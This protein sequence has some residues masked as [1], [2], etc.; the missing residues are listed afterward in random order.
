MIKLRWIVRLK[1]G[2]PEKV[3][4][5][6]QEFD[7]TIRARVPGQMWEIP[8]NSKMQWSPWTDVPTY[9]EA[10]DYNTNNSHYAPD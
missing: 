5:Y 1:D 6:A 7:T 9:F 3:L 8:A 4:Q 10:P 2:T